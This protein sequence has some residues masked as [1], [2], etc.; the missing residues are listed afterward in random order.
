M[1]ISDWS[2]DVC[3]SDLRR[4]GQLD[5]VVPAIVEQ[6]GQALLG[7][8][9]EV[10]AAMRADMQVRFE[11]AVENHLPAVRAFVPEV[12]RY[13]LLLHQRTDLGPHEV[14]QPVH[15]ARTPKSEEQT[16]ALQS[17]MRISYAL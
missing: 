4:L 14:G 12:V 15:V 5:P 16:S 3:S 9:P 6:H 1:R 13:V 7:R 11:I 10:V 2:S 17:P 8:D